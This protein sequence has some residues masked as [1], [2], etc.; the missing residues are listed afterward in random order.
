MYSDI[1]SL[2]AHPAMQPCRA[3]GCQRPSRLCKSCFH[4]ALTVCQGIHSVLRLVSN[5]GLMFFAVRW[6]I[7]MTDIPSACLS[8]H[9]Y[10]WLHLACSCAAGTVLFL[11]TA[12]LAT[13]PAV[14]AP[15]N[16]LGLLARVQLIRSKCTRCIADMLPCACAVCVY[17]AEPV[18]CLRSLST[19]MQ[20]ARSPCFAGDLERQLTPTAQT[21]ETLLALT[22]MSEAVQSAASVRYT[23]RAAPLLLLMVCSEC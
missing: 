9:L 4:A 21:C 16:G 19:R 17:A 13:E 7:V 15:M 1:V 8:S 12:L 20:C 14:F 23:V 3:R 2:S 22:D 18:L 5:C 6:C 10:R 11:R